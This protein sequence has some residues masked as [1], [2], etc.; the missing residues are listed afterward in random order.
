MA[1]PS[2]NPMARIRARPSG[3]HL[4]QQGGLRFR[5]YALYGRLATHRFGVDVRR[6]DL[7][8]SRR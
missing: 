4:Q 7:L 2:Q 8:A 6:L 1:H 5:T 3:D